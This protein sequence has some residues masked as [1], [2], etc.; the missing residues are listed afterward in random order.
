VV[1]RACTRLLWQLC[2]YGYTYIN[3][4]C[5]YGYTCPASTSS[6]SMACA[7]HQ[8]VKSPQQYDCIQLQIAIC[9]RTPSILNSLCAQ[10]FQRP[11]LGRKKPRKQRFICQRLCTKE[12]MHA[13]RSRWNCFFALV[14]G[15]IGLQMS[16]DWGSVN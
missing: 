11:S 2:R 13:R 7:V 9:V 10:T 12:H 4:M 8:S 5:R 3:H 16:C 1:V 6:S 14:S 15:R